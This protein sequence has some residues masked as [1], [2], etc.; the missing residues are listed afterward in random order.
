MDIDEYINY[1]AAE[2][3]FANTDWPGNNVKFWRPKREN[4]KM[5]MDLI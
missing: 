1:M 5:A 3:Y 2:I 4:G